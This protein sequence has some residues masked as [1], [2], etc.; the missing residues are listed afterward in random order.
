[1]MKII[2]STPPPDF[3]A[4][5]IVMDKELGQRHPAKT[6]YLRVQIENGVDHIDL[7]GAVTPIE[8]RRMARDKGYAPTHW[9]IV[10]EARPNVF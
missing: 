4:Q 10:G 5:V 1:M 6:F 9:M 7:D 3:P 2:D 8:A